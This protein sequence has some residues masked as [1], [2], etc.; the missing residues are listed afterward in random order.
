MP[1]GFFSRL[2]VRLLSLGE[3]NGIWKDAISVSFNEEGS[4][5]SAFLRYSDV[6]RELFL[7][8]AGDNQKGFFRTITENVDLLLSSWFTDEYVQYVPCPCSACYSSS[9]GTLFSIDECETAASKNNDAFCPLSGAVSINLLAPD[10]TLSDTERFKID[11]AELSDL[12]RIAEGAYGSVFRAK[13]NGMDVAVKKL[14]LDD[15][16]G[17]TKVYQEFRREVSF[18]PD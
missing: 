13:W 9:R 11:Y 18:D 14:N 10:L 4:S 1:M 8:V 2:C 7:E 5:T 15:D 16:V 12:N 3:R 17:P 6:N